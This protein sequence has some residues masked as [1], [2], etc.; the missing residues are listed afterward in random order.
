MPGAEVTSKLELVEQ[1]D[2]VR[3][4]GRG[5]AGL[6]R[7]QRRQAGGASVPREAERAVRRRIGLDPSGRSQPRHRHHARA[8]QIGNMIDALERLPCLLGRCDR[9][10]SD[11]R[12]ARGHAGQCKAAAHAERIETPDQPQ[13]WNRNEACHDQLHLQPRK[14]REQ[15]R[16][17][18]AVDDQEVEERQRQLQN[19]ELEVRQR[20]QDHDEGQRQR[21]ADTGPLQHRQQE[22]VQEHPRQHRQRDRKR[23]VFGGQEDRERR[24]MDENDQASQRKEPDTARSCAVAFADSGSRNG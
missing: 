24:E 7:W 13:Q 20:D 14:H 18:I 4:L 11:Q 1:H 3:P 6:V 23:S 10:H 19:S 9:H 16:K 8:R 12:G 21:G 17:R 5:V 22:A 15:K 2:D